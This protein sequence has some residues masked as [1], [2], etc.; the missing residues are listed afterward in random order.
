MTYIACQVDFDKIVKKKKKRI[1][2]FHL[3]L[4]EKEHREYSL[5]MRMYFLIPA[6]CE[7]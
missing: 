7:K 4:A 5:Q 1:L 6:N 2:G 3:G